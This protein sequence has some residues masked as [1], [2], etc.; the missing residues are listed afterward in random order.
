MF[1]QLFTLLTI[2]VLVTCTYTTYNTNTYTTCITYNTIRLLTLRTI[3]ILALLTIF[4]KKLD[5][6]PDLQMLHSE[7][8]TYL[9]YIKRERKRKKIKGQLTPVGDFNSGIKTVEEILG[10]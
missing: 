3:L 8:Q 9:R 10:I 6:L 2:H 5:Y 7:N 1:M 4:T